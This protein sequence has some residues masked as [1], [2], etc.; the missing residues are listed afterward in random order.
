MSMMT[1]WL[2][3]ADRFAESG[4]RNDDGGRG[5]STAAPDAQQVSERNDVLDDVDL[6]RQIARNFEADFLLTNLR[7]VPDLHWLSSVMARCLS[8]WSAPRQGGTHRSGPYPMPP[9]SA[10]QDV[11]VKSGPP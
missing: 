2:V 10:D 7:L 11:K 8:S 5:C 6:G 9:Q 4:A 3:G 1:N